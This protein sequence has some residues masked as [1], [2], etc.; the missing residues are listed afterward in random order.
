MPKTL[1]YAPTTPRDC[2]SLIRQGQDFTLT[3]APRPNWH[4]A[5]HL[6]IHGSVV[7]FLAAGALCPPGTSTIWGIVVES[8]ADTTMRVVAGIS[9]ALWLAGIVGSARHFRTWTVLELHSGVLVYTSP[10]VFRSSTT[11]HTL[12]DF[13][14]AVVASDE[15][16]THVRLVPRDE[17]QAA[18]TLLDGPSEVYY[19]RSELEFVARLLRDAIQ[20]ARTTISTPVI[21]RGTIR[22]A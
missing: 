17:T 4:T 9:A 21:G 11:R 3:L 1:S 12:S 20:E 2:R 6:L 7:V 10:G 14:D 15:G 13:L 16:S 22:R 18:Q 8:D 19:R 5:V